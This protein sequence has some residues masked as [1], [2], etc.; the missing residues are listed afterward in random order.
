M[1]DRENPREEERREL[2]QEQSLLDLDQVFR[3]R[4]ERELDNQDLEGRR[5]EHDR[6]RR[7]HDEA[8]RPRREGD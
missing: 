2:D 1:D 5:R 3:G 7:E 8:R 4:A 6:R